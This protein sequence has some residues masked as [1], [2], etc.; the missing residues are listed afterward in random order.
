MQNNN[1]IRSNLS[2]ADMISDIR[3]CLGGDIK[4]EHTYLLVEG[5]DDVKFIRPF[6]SENVYIYES[7]DG[8]NGVEEIVA[9]IF[10]RNERVIGIRDKDY[11]IEPI[12]NKVFYYDFCCMEMMLISNDDVFEE[13]CSECYEGE[14]NFSD[15]RLKIF[16]ELKFLSIIRLYNETRGWERKFKGISSSAAWSEEE[17]KIDKSIIINKINSITNSSIQVEMEKE[18]SDQL[19]KDWNLEDFLNYTQGHDFAN[20]MA[21]ICNIHKKRGIKNIDIESNLRCCFRYNDLKQTK[22][23]SNLIEYENENNIK[24]LR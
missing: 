18:I 1:S 23:Y 9:N 3:L 7:F 16:R 2:K 14:R 17:E 11:Q 10:E 12:S 15:L 13:V 6:L 24:I 5:D 4:R 21:T 22:L 20:L 8:K 19:E